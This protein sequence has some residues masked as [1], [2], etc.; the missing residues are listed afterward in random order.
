MVAYGLVEYLTTEALV[1]NMYRRK[2]SPLFKDPILDPNCVHMI[3]SFF[4]TV[5]R[6]MANGTSLITDIGF[7]S[8]VPTIDP[9]FIDDAGVRAEVRKIT[10]KTS[11]GKD[12][13]MDRD[14][15][16]AYKGASARGHLNSLYN[17]AFYSV[18][19]QMSLAFFDVFN[20]SELV[21][22]GDGTDWTAKNAK[23]DG[24]RQ[25]DFTVDLATVT[26]DSVTKFVNE[27]MDY[28]SEHFGS[29]EGIP[30]VWIV[31]RKILNMI[32]TYYVRASYRQNGYVREFLGN[33]DVLGLDNVI[34]VGVDD[35][36]ISAL[37]GG[38]E[39]TDKTQTAMYRKDAIGF[40]YNSNEKMLQFAEGRTWRDVAAMITEST[41][42]MQIAEVRSLTEKINRLEDYSKM[43]YDPYE[44]ITVN[45]SLYYSSF[46]QSPSHKN[47]YI[48]LLECQVDFVRLNPNNMAL[49]TIV[50]AKAPGGVDPTPTEPE[51]PT[52]GG[53]AFA[54]SVRR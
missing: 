35:K 16:V 40:F 43:P 44:P 1:S 25:K 30:Y 54:R 46:V 10:A 34:V 9:V 45:P 12:F 28:K 3:D 4:T 47:H 21:R 5:P 49:F 42:L 27:A 8:T 19:D 32:R 39:I 36:Y 20:D 13:A 41:E 18:K 17:S 2:V 33:S 53:D 52:G 22:K 37:T 51:S 48:M 15:F 50:E 38:T 26:V 24:V 14:T 11:G 7:R 31:P 23:D 6:Q 29:D